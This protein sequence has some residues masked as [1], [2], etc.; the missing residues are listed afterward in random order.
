VAKRRHAERIVTVCYCRAA[1]G[2][3]GVMHR[4]QVSS[5]GV[6]L[7]STAVAATVFAALGARRLARRSGVT[8]ADL[9]APLPGDEL[10]PRPDF[11]VDR[12]MG[13]PAPPAAVWP[14]LVQLGKGRAW[15][16]L[17]AWAERFVWAEDKRGARRIVPELQALAVGD[18]VPDWGPGDPVFR[19]AVLDPPHALVYHSLRQRSN[20]W[21]WPQPDT[22]R[23]PDCLELSW[24]LVLAPLPG[25]RARLHVRL[26]AAGV[27]RAK[28]LIEL[29]G[30]LIDY[31][32]IV[33]LFCGLGERLTTP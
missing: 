17:P 33:L 15:W 21:R 16:Y 12:A 24:A 31:V 20:Q 26:R 3:E 4:L 19:V 25:G 10:V 30:G 7:L 11:V 6:A 22:P 32:T 18:A 23:P 9:L 5:H 27:G 28:P 8:A 2:C 29:G 14:W 1:N 13:L